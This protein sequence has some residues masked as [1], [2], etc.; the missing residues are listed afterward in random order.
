MD[1]FRQT[2]VFLNITGMSPELLYELG[3]FLRVNMITPLSRSTEGISDANG[4]E[5]THSE[6]RTER[7]AYF[8]GSFTE[9]AVVKIEKW[10]QEKG[11][12]LKATES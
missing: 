5:R 3:E 6:P 9:P 12:Q 10:L 1:Y 11:G 2:V 4:K 7:V 8:A